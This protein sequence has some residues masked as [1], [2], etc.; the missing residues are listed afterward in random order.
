M[1][2]YYVQLIVFSI[3]I[4]FTVIQ[5]IVRKVSQQR[6]LKAEREL[7][8]RI[9]EEALRTGR[10]PYSGEPIGA[11]NAQPAVQAVAQP[12]PLAM[13][14][15]SNQPPDALAA[16]REQLRRLR[17]QRDA[18]RGETRQEPSP[19][20]TNLP[21]PMPTAQ[22]SS[23]GAPGASGPIRAELWPGGPT[24]VINP[25]ASAQGQP[26]A[27]AQDR[28]TLSQAAVKSAKKRRGAEPAPSP[29]VAVQGSATRTTRP[30][31]AMP[32]PVAPAMVEDRR[33]VARSVEL[34]KTAAQWRAALVLGE[35]MQPP[36]TER[37]PRDF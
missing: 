29:R 31:Q 20:R 16:R 6:A 10:D 2:Q 17:E 34:P 18:A 9:R 33:P 26:V 1:Q 19:A 23:S 14:M 4:G 15:Q 32:Q 25:G 36:V 30:V 28:P 21:P 8:A 5:W 3:F 7:Q 24:I 12:A 13:P 27:R 22:T 37:G 11:R 35:I